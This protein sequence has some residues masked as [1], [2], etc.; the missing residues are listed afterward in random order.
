MSILT[1]LLTGATGLRAANAGVNATSNNVANAST[2]G[3]NRRTVDQVTRD[4]LQ[5]G[6]TWF[7]Q[8]TNVVAIGRS[9]DRIINMR[10]LQEAGAAIQSET[11]YLHLTSVERLFD[12][13]HGATVKTYLDRFYDSLTEATGDPN[14]Y[15][16]RTEVTYAG[17]QLAKTVARTADTM[18]VQRDGFSETIE[19][20]LIETNAILKEI[21]D[22]NTAIF[23]AGGAMGAGDLAD[24]RDQLVR[25]LAEKVGVTSDLQAD[26]QAV[27]YLGGHAIVSKGEARE[28]AL[29]DST[30]PIELVVKAG[31]G[32]INVTDDAAGEIGGTLLAYQ[33]TSSYLAD[34]ETFAEDFST[35]FNTQHAAGFDRTGTA[36]G[37]LFSFTAGDAARSMEFDA[38]ILSDPTLLAFAGAVTGTAGDTDNL[39]LMIA[40]EEATIISGGTSTASAWMRELATGA[41]Q[42]VA[43]FMRHAEAQHTTLDDLDELYMNLHGVDMDQEAANLVLYQSAYQASA[44]VISVTNDLMST[45]IQLV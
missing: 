13:T 22:L 36:G 8:G 4:P 9:N 16:L 1:S 40:L 45:L 39:E 31:D 12:E 27:V 10:R 7:G 37:A 43:D 26:G 42:D 18:A 17:D 23:G 35:A 3:Y 33:R 14:D 24:R 30:I 5:R 41:G 2:P 29:V 44:K 32:L 19:Q 25:V 11:A 6:T 34:L 38:S 15:G 20:S 28:L 21:G